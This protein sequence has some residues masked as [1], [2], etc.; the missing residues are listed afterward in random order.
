MQYRSIPEI[1]VLEKTCLY[2][3]NAHWEII[4]V[5]VP[6]NQELNKFQQIDRVKSL[7]AKNWTDEHFQDNGAD[8]IAQK[9]KTILRI[10]CKGYN[11][12]VNP[13]TI[14]THFDRAIASLVSY[15]D[16]PNNL[17]IGLAVPD[18]Y[19]EYIKKRLP[20]ALR[21]SL[22]CFIFLLDTE[23]NEVETFQP[24]HNFL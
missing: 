16:S 8:I 11:W 14:K 9:G 1:D 18:L 21:K 19:L 2:L 7:I 6:K 5:S 24:S 22:N 13:Q 4:C 3:H 20:L 23:L 17:Q 12:G 15:Y 10:E